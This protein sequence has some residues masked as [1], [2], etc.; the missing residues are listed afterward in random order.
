MGINAKKGNAFLKDRIR[1][2][3]SRV[4]LA[5]FYR[6]SKIGEELVNYARSIPPEIGFTDRTGNLRSS[7]GYVIVKNG[8][9]VKEDFLTVVGSA[10]KPVD[11][12]EIGK[13]H[14]MELSKH[15]TN[16]YALI[17]VAGMNY[18]YAVESRGRDVLTSTEYQAQVK[19][20]TELQRLKDQ[21]KLM[22]V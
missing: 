14:A 17:F 22:K 20:P 9:V 19:L 10:P 7:V 1:E 21:I 5:I 2:V 8:S 12:K 6:L 18:A 13:N 3:K 15:H 4:D 16:G 11:G